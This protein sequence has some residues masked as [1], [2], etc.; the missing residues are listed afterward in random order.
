MFDNKNEKKGGQ[1][2]KL[3]TKKGKNTTGILSS[4]IDSLARALLSTIKNF[5]IGKKRNKSLHAF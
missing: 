4:E 1:D 3:M 5:S 2:Y